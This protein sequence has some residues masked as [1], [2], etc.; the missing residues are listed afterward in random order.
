MEPI[1]ISHSEHAYSQAIAISK[2][3][4]LIFFKMLNVSPETREKIWNKMADIVELTHEDM[5]EIAMAQTGS[6]RVSQN[7]LN[8]IFRDYIK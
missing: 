8:N 5:L 1:F 2:R 6:D 4:N 3:G 7:T